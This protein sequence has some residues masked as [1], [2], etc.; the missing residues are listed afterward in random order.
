[1]YGFEI[2]EERLDYEKI[3]MRQELTYYIANTPLLTPVLVK[4]FHNGFAERLPF[5]KFADLAQKYEVISYRAGKFF[6][7]DRDYIGGKWLE[8]FVF[9]KLLDLNFYDVKIGVK[10]R[11]Y[12]EDVINEID[13]MATKRNRLH[14]FSCKTGKNVKEILKHLYELEELTERIGGDFG[15]SYLVI[16]ENLIS[17]NFPSRK[18]FPNAPKVKYKG[19]EVLWYNYYKTPEGKRYKKLIAQYLSFQNLKKRAKLLK[20][21]LITPGK[22]GSLRNE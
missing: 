1:M 14:L 18:D 3:R 4:L 8:E 7:I 17:K 5:Q 2:V 22:L 6:V 10:V 15:K 16:T 12:G 21:G 11:W 20:I 19:N 9:L 13:V